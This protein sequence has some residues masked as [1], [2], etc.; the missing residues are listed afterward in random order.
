MSLRAGPTHLGV[1]PDHCC[2]LEEGFDPIDLRPQ[3]ALALA[4]PDVVKAID[5]LADAGQQMLA[6]SSS[7]SE[8]LDE[9]RAVLETRRERRAAVEAGRSP[10]GGSL[11]NAFGFLVAQ[12]PVQRLG[13]QF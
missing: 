8:V 7:V 1:A 12:R 13:D 2:S 3:E 9:L 10:L 5:F 4:Q 11:S 6:S